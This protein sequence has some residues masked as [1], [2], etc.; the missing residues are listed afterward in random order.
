M[1][2]IVG[3]WSISSIIWSIW[4]IDCGDQKCRGMCVLEVKGAER[5]WRGLMGG[6]GDVAL[7]YSRFKS[8]S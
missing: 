8:D 7:D 1:L 4:S 2:S 6:R 3:V 5:C